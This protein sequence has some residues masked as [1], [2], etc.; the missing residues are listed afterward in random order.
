MRKYILLISLFP[1]II[2]SQNS[3]N[4]IIY[5]TSNSDLPSNY[6][7]HIV[8]D[9][10]NRKWISVPDYGL[11]KIDNDSW[12]INNTSNSGIPSNTL[13]VIG[14]D[15]DNNFWAGGYGSFILSKFDG[16]NWN[17]WDNSNSSVPGDIRTALEFDNQN[18]VWFLSRNNGP[19]GS[20][21][22][23]VEF[24]DD[25]I[26][27]IHSSINSSNGYRQL[28]FDNN[29][30]LWI[31]DPEG[32]YFYDGIN[33]TYIPVNPLGQYVSDIKIDSTGDIWFALGE[34]GWGYLTKYDG[35]SFTTFPDVPA[36]SIE[37]D[38]AS[39]IWVGT[40]DLLFSTGA[41]LNKFDGTNWTTYNSSNSPLPA[42]YEI[43][44]L[45]FDKFGNLWIGTF[46]SGL[47]VFNEN[48]I[49]TPV[50]LLDFTADVINNSKVKL[51][52]S[53]ATETNNKGFE[54][55]RNTD[56]SNWRLIDFKEGNGTTTETHNYTFTDDLLG[57][58]L[59]KLYYRL[60]QIDFDG[61]FEYS[62][63]V[64]VEIAPSNYFLSQNYPNPFNPS[65]KIS[66]QSPLGGW[67]TLKIYDVL[68]NEVATLV[69]EYNPA[70]KYE[71]EF[72]GSD[73][74]SGIYFC[75]LK[76]GSFVETKKMIL[77]R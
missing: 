77:L 62:D 6:I 33:L 52:W 69:D 2:Y 12:T 50:E 16:T 64:E 24:S 55:E 49:V 48:G 20:T 43:T 29:Q 4:W 21:Y 72:D 18:H 53:T 13:N 63:I 57:V 45:E 40:L 75:Q 56:N 65:T 10:L 74:T 19:I 28:L 39:N 35:V 46:D 60:K 66:W 71:V 54:I 32:L 59:S 70:G 23:I 11:V 27:T 58:N 41:E 15:S 31:G 8:I 1:L 73:L 47:V 26:W 7:N 37:I 25:S 44:D 61:N 9:N 34:A 22:F 3:L 30:T 38:S 76:T 67:Q 68:G 36:I 5:N 17:V 51:D 14:V 42:T